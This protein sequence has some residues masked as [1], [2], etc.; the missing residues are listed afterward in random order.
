MRRL[1]SSGSTFE[2][3]IGYSRAV[4]AGDHIWVTGCTSIVDG[5]VV[6]EGDPYAQTAQ[7]IANVRW[8]L[9]ELDAD[10]AD[11]ELRDCGGG[12]RA[13]C[14]HV[15]ERAYYDALNKL[16]NDYDAVLGIHVAPFMVD[17]DPGVLPPGGPCCAVLGEDV[18]HVRGDSGDTGEASSDPDV[19]SGDTTRTW[20][21]VA[22]D[23]FLH[24]HSWLNRGLARPAVQRGLEV[25]A[26]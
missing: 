12:H 11:V 4:A 7:A 8:A 2:A 24:V 3:E 20:E 22:F 17:V 19:D 10:L 16:F 21:L 6:H 18:V 25:T 13:A 15:G 9:R 1:I 14:V 23:R 5:D 26:G